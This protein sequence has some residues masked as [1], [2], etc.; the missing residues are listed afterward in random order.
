MIY[1]FYGDDVFAGR[2]ELYRLLRQ[3]RKTHPHS[4]VIR[5]E[6]DNFDQ[7]K[8]KNLFLTPPLFESEP[9]FL[10]ENFSSL[11]PSQ[12][13]FLLNLFSQKSNNKIIFWDQ[14]ETQLA[15][16]LKKKFPQIKIN[17]FSCPKT[18]FLFLSKIAPG[19]EKFFLPFWQKLTAQYPPE[20]ILFFLKNHFRLLLLAKIN[21]QL[22]SSLPSWRQQKILAQGKNFSFSQL[23]NFYLNLIEKEYQ[24]KTGQLT[25]DLELALVNLLL[26]L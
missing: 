3:F 5:I 24:Q 7:E 14:K 2:K 25:V 22:I 23:K 8:I 19:K 1:Y 21:P 18:I 13:K 20:L 17:R 9:I 4:R 15:S 11:S 12:Q 16:Q 10:I 26:T 6:K